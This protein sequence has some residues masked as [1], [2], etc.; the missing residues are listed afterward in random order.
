[1]I[2]MPRALVVAI[3]F[4]SGPLRLDGKIRYQAT[5]SDPAT[6]KILAEGFGDDANEAYADAVRWL[7]LSRPDV[8]AHFTQSEPI[9]ARPQQGRRSQRRLAVAAAAPPSFSTLA[10]TGCWEQARNLQLA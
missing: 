10:D 9:T 4:A 3:D 1:M 7:R 5:L 2:A 8:Y 6:D